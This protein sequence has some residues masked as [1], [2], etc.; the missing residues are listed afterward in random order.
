MGTEIA[1]KGPNGVTKAEPARQVPAGT[2][3]EANAKLA[4]AW[5]RMQDRVQELAKLSHGPGYDPNLQP[6]DVMANLDAIQNPKKKSFISPGVKEAFNNTL[7]AV[8]KVGGMIADAASQVFAPAGQCYNALNFVISAWQGYQEV[9]GELSA[10]FAECGQF[11][12]R[13]HHYVAGKM[14]ASLTATACE[15]LDVFVE[16][17]DKAMKIR[18]SGRF[19]F[20]TFMKIA[21]FSKD[22][23]LE[24]TNTM[25]GLTKKE[26]LL[27]AAQTYEKASKAAEYSKN[28]MGLL[29]EDR[30]E[31]SEQKKAL[32]DRSQIL[33]ILN[34]DN[35]PDTWDST[36][37]S[38]IAT[39]ATTY[40]N[41]RQHNVEGTGQWLLADK[42]FQTWMSPMTDT[43]VLALVGP[44]AAGKSY[45]ASTVI[46][47]LR[48]QV[49]AQVETS[50]RLVGFYFL[51][52]RKANAGIDVLG[53]SIIWQFAD[54]DA[55]YMQSAA[56]TC[57]KAGTID[58]TRIM[59]R[60]LLENHDELA[61]VDVTFFIVINKLGD[62]KGHV[63]PA[64]VK[65]LQQAGRCQ[66]RAVRVLFTTTQDTIDRLERDQFTCPAIQ[67]QE[68]NA[69]DAMKYIDAR[70]DRI[71]S[72][73]DTRQDG[74][75]ELR[76]EIQDRLYKATKGNYYM[77]D[78]TLTK[79]SSLDYDK[80]IKIALDGA[81]RS[82][83]DHIVDD[84][85]RLNE[86]LSAKEID[87]I[88]KIILWTSFAQEQVTVDIMSA[89]LRFK[90]DAVS[91]TPLGERLKKKFLLFE[92]DN[93]G[94]VAFRSEKILAAIP[95]RAAV[96]KERQKED[97]TVNEGEVEILRHFLK[98]V[99]PPGLAEKLEMEQHFQQKL[100]A[101]QHQIYREDENNAH[102]QLAKVCLHALANKAGEKLRPL[103]GYAS[104]QLVYHMSQVDLA[105]IDPELKG[106]IGPDLVNLFR[107]QDSIDNLLW[108]TKAV[109]TFPD[110]LLERSQMAKI[111]GWL[112]RERIV[113]NVNDEGKKWLASL[114]GTTEGHR[115]ATIILPCVRRMAELC[116]K[117][118]SS[119]LVTVTAFDCL[120]HYFVKMGAFSEA[121]TEHSPSPTSTHVS[122][123]EDLIRSEN[124]ASN[125]DSLWETQM[126]Y[127]YDGF[128]L[129]SKAEER[130]RNALRDAPKGA[131]APWRPSLLLAK[132]TQS[133]TEAIDNLKNLIERYEHDSAWMALHEKSFAE[134]CFILANR[135]WDA[136]MSE[137]SGQRY[138][139]CLQHDPTNREFFAMILTKYHEAERWEDIVGFF[140]QLRSQS[141]LAP[142]ALSLADDERFHEIIVLAAINTKKYYIFDQIYLEAIAMARK[143]RDHN[144]AFYLRES[145][146]DALAV[147]PELPLEKV[148]ELLETAAMDDIPKTTLNPTVAFF[149]IGYRLGRIYLDK[150]IEAKNAGRPEKAIETLRM[151]QKVVPEQVNE[152]QMRLPLRLFSARYYKQQDDL[153]SAWKMAHN[154]LQMAIELLSDDDDSNDTLAYIKILHAAIPFGDEKNARA[155]L[156]L[157]KVCE[158]DRFS[159]KCSCKCGTQWTS[160]G[161]MWWC[162][163]CINMVLTPDCYKKV[164]SG[165][166]FNNI[167]HKNHQHFFLPSLE[168]SRLKNLP[169][170][171]VPWGEEDIPLDGWKKEIIKTYHLAQKHR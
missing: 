100:S 109:P 154:T 158:G 20:K 28:T 9:F 101:R 85:R 116:L 157:T 62:K 97:P 152:D 96:V 40:Q 60:L 32:N 138:T 80:D 127:V 128:S 43:P 91:L 139:Q 48:T 12:D 4:A 165:E 7:T 89:V 129:F 147:L 16:I 119:A 144:A 6:G 33:K 54:G 120:D 70:M 23:F 155:A 15:V 113:A 88:N 153:D 121:G 10:L 14:N 77:M 1:I 146:A 149:L 166:F 69:D 66:R 156:A 22:E 61:G 99:C 105:E 160:P 86:T 72:L 58:P 36:A 140:E 13:L 75:V 73:S 135:Y 102:F 104:R 143:S 112:S 8:S 78:K 111:C 98:S 11:L 110:W 136:G 55:S 53:K 2:D 161:N 47:H 25:N 37:Q 151:M 44:E 118:E 35:T 67:I 133:D 63:H 83:E 76:R 141:Q 145:Y 148:T 169:K 107:D 21:F 95:E 65:F 49:T 132:V 142:M 162:M 3:A 31:R 27:V 5:K 90:N 64:V 94:N 123:V 42:S 122:A 134:M 74:I 93:Y 131:N 115:F 87:E 34:F 17:C 59:P 81:G 39:W 103:R 24:L 56:T 124:L 126:G 164:K 106:Q 130:C 108:A 168:D 19:K 150:A 52:E 26:S 41:I 57:R 92:I 71:D 50:R 18:H 125:P 167:C 114:F 45:L 170:N 82:L 46:N 159:L 30:Q 117:Q 51:D 68:R 79:I 84:V 171:H 38:P 29:S 163:D 137:N